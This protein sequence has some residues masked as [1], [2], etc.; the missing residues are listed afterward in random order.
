[1]TGEL[2]ITL[3]IAIGGFGVVVATAPRLS[4]TVKAL[5]SFPI[6]V[7]VYM[8]T[9][10]LW[11]VATDRVHPARILAATIALGLVGVAHAVVT[12]QRR[13]WRCGLVMVLAVAAVTML[14]RTFHLTQLT[15]DSLRY[16]LFAL[17]VSGPE[18]IAAVHPPDLLNRQLGYPSLQALASLTDR[19]YLASI[20]P[21]LGA[22]TLGLLT[23]TLW[24]GTAGDRR[25]PLLVA[26]AVAFL[27]S[28]NRFLYSWFYI[29]THI[30]IAAFLLIAVS[31][32]WWA[33]RERSNAW[34]WPV[35][36][37][38]GA[39]VV[40]RPDSPLFAAV[41]LGVIAASS[42]GWSFRLPAV[43][44]IL[45]IT[46]LWYGLTLVPHPHYQSYMSLTS[47]VAGNILA[48]T[49]AV[50]LVLLSWARPF[51]KLARHVD[52]VMLVAMV[53]GFSLLAYRD[54]EVVAHSAYATVMNVYQGGW[55]LTW[56]ALTALTLLV[57]LRHRIPNGR[58]WTI[59][60]MGFG[61]LYWLLPLLREGA[62]R[63]GTGDSG[64][65]I[66]IH[67]VAIVVGMVVLG[68]SS[69]TVAPSVEGISKNVANGLRS[70]FV[71]VLP[72]IL[73]GAAVVNGG[74]TSI[75][76]HNGNPVKMQPRVDLGGIVHS[77]QAYI[78]RNYGFFFRLYE[79]M[80]GSELV[81]HTDNETSHRALKIF[82][83]VTPVSRR[84]DVSS[85]PPDLWPTGDPL[86]T[87]RPNYQEEHRYWILPGTPGERRWLA[88]IEPGWV[89]VPESVHPVPEAI[90]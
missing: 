64:N 82:G 37:S 86:G 43:A 16:L 44:P 39:I 35:G 70:T 54:L 53:A 36:I 58:V 67:F 76:A 19:D 4:G 26:V 75:N 83:Q 14:A 17:N 85:L 9:A 80:R 45:V 63:V 18:G 5:L 38:I 52:V 21:L 23:W 7:A 66:L 81:I 2:L 24:R 51:R 78:R 68:A 32:T 42:L 46:T 25:R 69:T 3:G 50:A 72:L 71:L 55:L 12:G 79:E 90:R 13:L 28:T 47:P 10:S 73:G 29:N 89:V 22:S 30:A 57:I 6:G 11:V 74:L 56:P 59:P 48:V 49:G 60:V 84:F 41:V 65:R 34:A 31:G 87:F 1:M 40:L 20:G 62:W 8:A 61:L 77:D 33:V 15:P 88:Q 27:L